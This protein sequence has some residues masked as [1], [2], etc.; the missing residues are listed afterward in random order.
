MSEGGRRSSSWT[1]TA[2]SA[3]VHLPPTAALPVPSG[4]NLFP[5]RGVSYLNQRAG[6]AL[7][8]LPWKTGAGW[9]GAPPGKRTRPSRARAAAAEAH[10]DAAAEA[11]RQG[12][13]RL[14]P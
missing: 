2:C 8:D 11:A 7:L 5:E 9:P 6:P 13:G 10:R 1:P 14:V 12:H 4:L 3:R